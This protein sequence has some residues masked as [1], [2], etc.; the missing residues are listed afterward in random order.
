M[1]NA[2]SDDLYPSDG[3]YFNFSE[4]PEQ[5]IARKKKKAQTLEALPV[6]KELLER[7]DKQVAFLSSVDAMPDECK[8]DPEKFMNFHNASQIARDIL[9]AEKEYIE[10]LI[11]DYHGR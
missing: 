2:V 9:R 7:L 10:G 4:P 8:L 11:S 6:L 5:T 3:S 1:V